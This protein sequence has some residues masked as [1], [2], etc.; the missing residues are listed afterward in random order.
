[1]IAWIADEA[2]RELVDFLDDGDE[3]VDKFCVEDLR[4]PANTLEPFNAQSATSY[5]PW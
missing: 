3:G 5:W 2:L 1:M 4:G